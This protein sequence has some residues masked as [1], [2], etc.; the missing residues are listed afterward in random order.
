MIKINGKKY[1]LTAKR[2]A[3]LHKIWNI[4]VF[5]IIVIGCTCEP[6]SWR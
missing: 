2:K 5:I 1:R 4:I 6:V 3:T